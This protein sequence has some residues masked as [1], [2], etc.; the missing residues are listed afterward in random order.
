[1]KRFASL[2]NNDVAA[3]KLLLMSQRTKNGNNV[4]MRLFRSYLAEK[5]QDI[6]FEHFEASDQSSPVP[7]LLPVS[8][9]WWSWKIK[10]CRGEL[11]I[12]KCVENQ[13]WVNRFIDLPMLAAQNYEHVVR[14]RSHLSVYE[15]DILV[16]P[17]ASAHLYQSY[18]Y[19]H[20][21]GTHR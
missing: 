13:Q 7:L 8:S 1:M 16:S 19:E 2:N 18:W 6:D 5:D 21:E 12:L 17:Q 4:T 3:K 9:W 10:F 15:M 20:K 11:K 14:S